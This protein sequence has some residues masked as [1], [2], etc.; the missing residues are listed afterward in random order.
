MQFEFTSDPASVVLLFENTAFQ[1]ST[2]LVNVARYYPHSA[3][4]VKCMEASYVSDYIDG[5]GEVM[6][7][8]LNSEWTALSSLDTVIQILLFVRSTCSVSEFEDDSNT[9]ISDSFG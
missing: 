4:T 3:P 9:M 2:F 8:G 5:N 1:P 6:H 7:A